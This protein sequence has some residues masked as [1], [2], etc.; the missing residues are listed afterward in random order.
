MVRIAVCDDERET[1]AELEDALAGV[2]C[3]MDVACEISCFFSARDLLG[4]LEDGASFDLIYLDVSFAEGEIDGAAAGRLIRDSFM[5]DDALIVY[6]SWEEGHSMRLHDARPMAFLIKPLTRGKIEK[7]AATFMRL[8]NPSGAMELA[9]KKR[10]ETH[11]VP[12]KDVRYLEA[13]GRMV[14]L[15]MRGGATDEF[16]GSLK[17]VW[18]RQLKARDFIFVHASYAVNYDW[19]GEIGV[20]SLLVRGCQA[21][22]PISRN[23]RKETRVRYAQIARRRRMQA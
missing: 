8:A 12:I 21:I 6:I 22:L 1:V 16:Y 18:E 10:H 9:Y 3:G 7:S 14:V 4:A 11:R 17:D 23:R 5:D 19:V 13:R 20:D 15:H 2:F